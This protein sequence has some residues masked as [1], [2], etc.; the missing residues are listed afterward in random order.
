MHRQE[1]G[2]EEAGINLLTMFFSTLP[3]IGG[4]LIKGHF[5]QERGWLLDIVLIDPKSIWQHFGTILGNF[6]TVFMVK[7]HNSS[8]N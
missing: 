1:M 6:C 7:K 8:T 3:V 4:W 2:T 5:G